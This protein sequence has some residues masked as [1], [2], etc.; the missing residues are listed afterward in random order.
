MVPYREWCGPPGHLLM[1]EKKSLIK[2]AAAPLPT[3]KCTKAGLLGQ[4]SLEGI[5]LSH[6][7][8][9]DE[10]KELRS[11]KSVKKLATAPLASK[12]CTNAGYLGYGTL[13]GIGLSHWPSVYE[14]EEVC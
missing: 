12:M 14:G 5:G 7:P 4:G 6:W 1:K 13:E 2:L 9:V 8:S 11:L 3:K 10:G